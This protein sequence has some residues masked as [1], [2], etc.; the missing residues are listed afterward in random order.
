M[1]DFALGAGFGLASALFFAFTPNASVLHVV[2]AG[3]WLPPQ[4]AVVSFIVGYFFYQA[5]TTYREAY[6]P[7][8]SGDQYHQTTVNIFDQIIPSPGQLDLILNAK[9]IGITFG[10]LIGAI[11]LI[12]GINGLSFLGLSYGVLGAV[13]LGSLV[14]DKKLKYLPYLLVYLVVVGFAF[15]LLNQFD[16]AQPVIVFG[17]SF[18]AIPSSLLGIL[19]IENKEI[20]SAVVIPLECLRMKADAKILKKSITPL[21]LSASISAMSPGVSSSAFS[22]WFYSKTEGKLAVYAT[23][24]CVETIGAIFGLFGVA[25]G[26][27]FVNL[28]LELLNLK[29]ST[30]FVVSTLVVSYFAWEYGCQVVK[31]KSWHEVNELAKSAA[32]IGTGLFINVL[33]LVIGAG[34]LAIPLMLLGTLTAYA[35]DDLDCPPGFKSLTFL[36]AIAIN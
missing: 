21:M 22:S 16:V 5:L 13:V 26:S 34:W 31:K 29:L 27:S 17:L 10:F 25:Y 18:F 1:F 33:L 6:R 2:A 15:W 28:E 8:L 23:E 36:G 32:N 7:E 30:V 35:L 24:V 14:K 19:K 4:A 12:T 9:T 3:A 11:L 20:K